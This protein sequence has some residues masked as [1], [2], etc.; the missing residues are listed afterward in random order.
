MR[1]IKPLLPSSYPAMLCRLFNL[2]L[3]TGFSP[4]VWNSADI[5]MV[6]NNS[7]RPRDA[8]NFRPIT[9]T[10]IH[11]KLFERL[12]L[13]HFFD[14]SGWAKLHP[15]Q[16]GFR[17]DDSTLTDATVVHH[18]LS[19]GAVRYAAFIDLE[20]AFDVNDHTRLSGLLTAPRCP[21]RVLCLIRSLTFQGVR[22]FVL[23]NGQSSYW[24][25][26]SREDL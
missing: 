4:R 21:H 8:G 26:H 22:S 24:F 11:R 9:L 2:C 12:L 17:G 13:V 3:S 1:V 15:T 25:S 6:T 5:H 18:L 10:C 19:T 20:K 23:V 16:A 14:G 7:S